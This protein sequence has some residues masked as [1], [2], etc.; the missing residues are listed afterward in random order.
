M[1]KLRTGNEIETVDSQKIKSQTKLG[2]Q[3]MAKLW[4][5]NLESITL[6]PSNANFLFQFLYNHYAVLRRAYLDI[7]TSILKE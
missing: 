5:M 2:V 1:I 3:E 7:N 6:D 4:L